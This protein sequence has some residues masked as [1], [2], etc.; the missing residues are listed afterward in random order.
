MSNI[1]YLLSISM[2]SKIEV[3]SQLK[4]QISVP[5]QSF[6]TDPSLHGPTI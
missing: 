6:N 2:A 1:D 4:L 3:A 5:D